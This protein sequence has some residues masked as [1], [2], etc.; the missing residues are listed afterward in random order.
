M[1]V[2]PMTDFDPDKPRT[3][4]DYIR[5]IWH[6]QSEIASDLAEVKAE[7]KRTNGRV[8]RLETG[9]KVAVALI[10]GVMV[11]AGVLNLAA[12]LSML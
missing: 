5:A 4:A 11:G 3:Q 7:T 10:V 12:L 6:K 8:T 9:A 2:L 1:T